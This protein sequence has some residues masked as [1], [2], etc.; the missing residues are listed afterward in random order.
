[1]SGVSGTLFPMNDK[2]TT[3]NAFHT[4]TRATCATC[5]TDRPQ[6]DNALPTNTAPN[7]AKDLVRV[8]GHL[9]TRKD[10]MIST[11][12]TAT[13]LLKQAPAMLQL[14]R[15]LAQAVERANE[16]LAAIAD[17]NRKLRLIKRSGMRTRPEGVLSER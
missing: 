13:D 14:E 2:N 15:E 3:R 17:I 16:A 8:Y 7:W 9:D 10:T 4:E 6:A 12:S 11:P 1:M 5:A